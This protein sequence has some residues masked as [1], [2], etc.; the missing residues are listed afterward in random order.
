MIKKKILIVSRYFYPE[1]TPRAFRTTELAIEFVRQGHNVT[2]LIPKSKKIHPEFEQEQQVLIKDFGALRWKSPDFGKS[3]A[4]RLLT[5]AVF[6]F[7]SLGF[8]YPAIELMFKVNKALKKEKG[9]DLLISIAVPYPIHWGVALARSNSHPIATT[10]VADC[11]DPYMGCKTDSFRKPFYFKYVEKWFMRKT[12]YISI[13]KESFKCNYYA[14]FHNKIAEIPQGFRINTTIKT[15]K[16]S[17]NKTPH[18]A[19]AG[20]LMKGTRDPKKFMTYLASV[21][22]PFLF[23]IFTKQHS[24]VAPF[25]E[26]L[27]GKIEILDYIPR[28]D[29]LVQLS[30]MDFLVNFEYDPLTQSPS[31]LIDYAITKRPILNIISANFNPEA[32]DEFLDGNYRLQMKLPDLENYKIENVVK[33]FLALDEN[34]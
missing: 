29:L 5:R 27:G 23:T 13:T 1:N 3:K 2:L 24:L 25:R 20:T 26:K 8:E 16:Q 15:K 28:E 22:K 6:R 18:F 34:Q 14:E 33:K 31:K 7:L 17:K 30:K 10:W 11:G 21:Q 12:N 19:F 9:Y 4:G 32:I